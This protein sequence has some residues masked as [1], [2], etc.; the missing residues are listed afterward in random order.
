MDL[1]L[2][3]TQTAMQHKVFDDPHRFVVLAKGRRCGGT[4]GA[5]LR[6]MEDLCDGKRVLWIDTVQVNLSNYFQRYFVPLLAGVSQDLW[7]W[8]E[9]KKQFKFLKG[10]L[11]M[12]SAEIPKNIEG[13]AY[14]TIIINEAGLVFLA[15]DYLWYNAIYPMVMDYEARVFFVGTPKG[16][17]AKRSIKSTGE[18]TK[19]EHLFYTFFKM[20]QDP[21]PKNQWKSF[22]ISS[23]DNPKIKKSEIEAYE[24]TVPASIRAQEIH[25]QFVDMSQDSIFQSSWWQYTDTLPEGFKV[26]RRILSW[27][28]AF[29][30]GESNDYSVCTYWIQ[31]MD[32]FICA[33]MF[34]GRL[35]FPALIDK[36]KFLYEKYNPDLVLIEDKASGQSLIQMFQ[37]TT[38]P[39]TP[40]KIDKDKIS[41]AVA[42]TPLIEQGKV[43]LL[44]GA[45]NQ[46][47][48]DQA[49]LFPL[50]EYDDAVDSLSQ[51]LLYLSGN[52]YWGDVRPILSKKIYTAESEMQGFEE[53]VFHNSHPAF[54][55]EKTLTG[56]WE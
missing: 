54:R 1:N 26:S 21:D 40:F 53:P 55:P 41:R 44:K 19:N 11:D 7:S 35:T 32:K 25:A 34:M 37:R 51:A 17:L 3:L 10:F 16:K 29:K 13:F 47:L 6:V 49:T 23:Y 5:V 45:W 33:D 36:T 48:I 27:D 42:I 4:Y 9:Q 31:T 52:N 12:R 56:F 24:A 20:G 15:D 46:V 8:N 14:N 18:K 2:N 43:L 30:D 50:A 28:T 38:M 39:I 22:Q